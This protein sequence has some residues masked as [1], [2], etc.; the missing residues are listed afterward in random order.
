[1]FA[2]NTTYFS[3]LIPPLYLF[4]HFSFSNFTLKSKHVVMQIDN[5]GH[6]YGMGNVIRR[7]VG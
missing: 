5:V 4:K 3:Y 2:L 7:G 1:M 6:G